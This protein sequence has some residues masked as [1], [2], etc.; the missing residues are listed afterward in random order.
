MDR[1]RATTTNP[2]GRRDDERHEGTSNI[3]RVRIPGYERAFLMSERK[4]KAT[5]RS[6]QLHLWFI[7][8]RARPQCGEN[9]ES[10][11]G[12]L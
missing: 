8:N 5:L 1:A 4:S 9:Q 11:L 10:A 2:R 7:R 12:K 3:S 6:H